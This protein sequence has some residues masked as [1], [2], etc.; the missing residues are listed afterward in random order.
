MLISRLPLPVCSVVV[1]VA[2][3]LFLAPGLQAQSLPTIPIPAPLRC[4]YAQPAVPVPCVLPS[5]VG[6]PTGSASV[7]LDAHLQALNAVLL[8]ALPVT[9][10]RDS[11]IARFDGDTLGW[12]VETTWTEIVGSSGVYEVSPTLGGPTEVGVRLLVGGVSVPV[13]IVFAEL[14]GT[15][16]KF[17]VS[18]T[19]FADVSVTANQVTGGNTIS[20]TPAGTPGV[21]LGSVWVK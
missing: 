20:V 15:P 3:L 8:P 13:D 12:A 4:S 6:A 2:A 7:S 17:G 18:T 14:N 9:G 21:T 1:L 19:V 16:K 11:K 5:E 10:A